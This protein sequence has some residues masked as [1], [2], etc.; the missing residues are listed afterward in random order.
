LSAS[1]EVPATAHIPGEFPFHCRSVFEISPSASI[2]KLF[3]A[4][5]AYGRCAFFAHF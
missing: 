3:R 1:W 2:D 5:F 4:L